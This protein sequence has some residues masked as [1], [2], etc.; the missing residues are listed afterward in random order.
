MGASQRFYGC[1]ILIRK[2]NN[3]PSQVCLPTK[4]AVIVLIDEQRLTRDAIRH[5]LLNLGVAY[6]RGAANGFEANQAFARKRFD[7]VFISFNLNTDKDGFH[8]LEELKFKSYITHQ[9]TVIFLSAETNSSLVNSVI[10]LQPDDFWTKPLKPVKIRAR[11]KQV[12]EERMIMCKPLMYA[13]KKDYSKAIYYAQQII[14]RKLAV[15]HNAKLHRLVIS[16]LINLGELDDAQDYLKALLKHADYA[17]IHIGLVSIHLKQKKLDEVQ[18]TILRLKQREDT[19]F[20][21]HDLLANYFTE[22]KEFKQA[23]QETRIAADLAQTLSGIKLNDCIRQLY[24]H[25]SLLKY[26][27]HT[28]QLKKQLLIIEARLLNIQGRKSTADGF[29]HEVGNGELLKSFEDKLDLMKAFHESG[30]L[31]QAKL[32]LQVLQS[33]LHKS[34]ERNLILESYV[35]QELN[36]RTEIRFSSKELL[37]MSQNYYEAKRFKPALK[38]L[39][40]A[41]VLSPSNKTV[42]M[43]ILRVARAQ[44]GSGDSFSQEEE[45]TVTRCFTLLNSSELSHDKQE[46]FTNLKHS[47]YMLQNRTNCSAALSHC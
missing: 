41:F 47:L 28:K 5:E 30:N 37:T 21:I 35:K 39:V 9:T 31:E 23:Y 11:I 12:I 7:L 17:W 4:K 19:K 32:T 10:E 2:I 42:A 40:Q 34:H 46:E 6:I 33:E 14:E 22:E 15:A 20:A 3:I 43:A 29:L 38:C 16:C 1:V 25:L 27:K 8:L 24:K 44:H 13:D 36:E 45:D 18:P 26:G